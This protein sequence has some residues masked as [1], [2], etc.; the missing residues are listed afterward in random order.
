M[1]I[2]PGTRIGPYEITS[3]LGEGGMGVVFRA[4]DVKLQ[5]DVAIKLLPDDFMDDT[6]RLLRFK[7]EAQVLA[8]LNH[9][10]VAQIYGFEESGNTRCIVMELVEGETLSER[11]AASPIP[12]E[13]ALPIAAQIAE[14]LE[15]AHERGVIHR[16]LKPANI[17]LTPDGK[18]KVLDFGLAKPLQ[19]QEAASF[20][21]SPT[22]VSSSIPGVILGTPAYLSPE[23][24]RGRAVDKSTDIWAFGC[25]LFEMLTGRQ[26]F[27]GETVPDIMAS[28]LSRDVNWQ[29]LPN[30][31]PLR[32]RELIARCLQKDYRRRLRDAGDARLEIEDIIRGVRSPPAA[33]ESGPGRTAKRPL[34]SLILATIVVALVAV[35][36]WLAMKRPVETTWVGTRLGGP[37]LAWEPRVSPDGRLVAFVTLAEGTT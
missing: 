9:P 7:R 32:L 1:P 23:Q 29:D 26:A 13:D 33:V 35:V 37:N 11:I 28:I 27:G 16:D 15:A 30:A 36:V 3:Y 6:D 17:K 31:T 21:H 5:R 14:A 24:A 8:S 18:V 22:V 25:V 10:N 12:I 2:T 20:S 34:V 4:R 19:E